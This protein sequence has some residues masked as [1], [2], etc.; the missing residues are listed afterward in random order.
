MK[1]MKVASP[2]GLKN[3]LL[4]Q[5]QEPSAPGPG[6]VLL[7]VSASSLNYHDYIVASR[8]DRVA[9]GR[10]PLADGAGTVEAVGEGVVDF[11]PGDSVV[12]CF[13]PDW[14]D[15][16]AMPS[17]FTR[18]PGDGIDG[19]GQEYVRLP[20]HWLT[21]SPEGWAPEEAATITTAGVTAWRALVVDG[22]IKAG[23][24]V[25]VLGTGGVSI[26]ALQLAKAMGARVIATTSSPEKAARLKELGADHVINYR[27]VPQWGMEVRRLTDGRGAD[28]VV[29][30]G[31]AGT[32]TQSIS[33][34]AVGGFIALIGVLTG[35]VGE[36]PTALLMTR[37]Q[38]LQGM[39][40]GSRQHQID[41]IAALNSIGIRPV[42]DRVFPL[43]ELA[44]AF[45]WQAGGN[46]F[47]KIAITI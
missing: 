23:N 13:F 8:P 25:L 6:E 34:A 15:G 4:A 40:V 39:I 2:G 46:H 19:F 5:V 43:T 35:G 45:E 30:V 38:R 42:I 27:E 12:S 16:A 26:Y 24:T 44:S 32:L 14:Q 18:V 37:Q 1:Q 7:K 29:E 17:D 41:L 28:I 3:L 21:H 9:D 33:A 10:I 31:G 47:G 11:R 20:A 36:I 22:R